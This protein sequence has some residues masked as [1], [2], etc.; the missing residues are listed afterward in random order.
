M[1]KN[2]L[3]EIILEQQKELEKKETGVSR[4]IISKIEKSLKIP[5]SVV[6][7][8]IRRVGKSTLLLQIIRKY[9]I[10]NFYYLNFEDERLINFREKDFNNLYEVMLELLG[11]NKTFFFDEIQNV[12]GWENFVRR[13]Q[14]KGFKFFLTGSNASMLSREL[15]T[16]LTGRYL[17]YELYPFSFTEYLDFKG[18]KISKSSLYYT[19]ERAKLKAYFN[20]YLKEGGMP[21]YLIYKNKEILKR[22]YEDILYRDI[23]TRYDIQE[24]KSLRELVLYYFSNFA[25]LV[26]FN[27]LK[28]I[29]KLGSVHTVKNYTDYLENSY[30]FFAVNIFSYKISQ[31][32]IAPKKIYC[33]DNGLAEAV[34]YSFSKN[35]GRFLENL[36]FIELK[37]RGSEI[38][39]YKTKNNEE[40]DFVLR[41]GRDVASIIQVSEDI[42]NKETKNREIKALI[43]ALN[44]LNLKKGLLLTSDQKE[45]IKLENKTIEIIPVYE[46]LLNKTK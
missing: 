4:E 30:L 1:E 21:E 38:Y 18:Y 11:I 34:S 7:S 19:K 46:W 14:D 9:Y 12:I 2:L 37:R 24:V 17:P 42:S 39:Y 23:V 5:H 3:K 43:H 28:E 33:V 35:E 16:K 15:G 13:M 45:T 20:K 22:I 40:V 26:S 6:L 41:R 25:N 36:V 29:L 32:F 8:G 31:Q 10:N 44:E 27:K